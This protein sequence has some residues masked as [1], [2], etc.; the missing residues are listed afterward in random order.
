MHW[1][2]F[3]YPRQRA[4]LYKGSPLAPVYG[5]SPTDSMP[6]AYTAQGF[7]AGTQVRVTADPLDKIKIASNEPS[8]PDGRGDH[9]P[10]L[11]FDN[12]QQ[13]IGVWSTSANG[14]VTPAVGPPTGFADDPF[15]IGSEA[16]IEAPEGPG[17]WYLALAVNDGQLSDNASFWTVTV[18]PV[19]P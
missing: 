5:P 7:A 9:C 13:L 16:T 6:P 1:R 2:Q 18:T 12:C 17:P 8:V 15:E 3:A 10:E 4:Y 11:G 19:C 14:P